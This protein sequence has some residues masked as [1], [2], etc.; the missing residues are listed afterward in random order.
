MIGRDTLRPPKHCNRDAY[1]LQVRE[2]NVESTQSRTFPLC[3]EIRRPA[4]RL[5][6]TSL[7]YQVSPVQPLVKHHPAPV[8]VM[9][10]PLPTPT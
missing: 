10:Y 8:H 2:D 4:R 7:P 6:E 1:F 3:N 9:P 5:V